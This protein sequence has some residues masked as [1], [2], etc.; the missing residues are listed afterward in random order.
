M[1]FARA[2]RPGQ[3]ASEQRRAAPRTGRDADLAVVLWLQR[4][5][6]K[7]RP[8]FAHAPIGPDDLEV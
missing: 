8:T 3:G 5:P 1:S 7:S 2:S 4:R 6:A